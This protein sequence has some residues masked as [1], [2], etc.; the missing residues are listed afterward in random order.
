MPPIISR[1]VSTG[2]EKIF[3]LLVQVTLTPGE[4]MLKFYLDIL[5]TKEILI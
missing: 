5:Y 4:T 2:Q 3:P 1:A